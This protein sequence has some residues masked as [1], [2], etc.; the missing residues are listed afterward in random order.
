MALTL[1]QELEFARF[2]SR[3]GIALPKETQVSGK[4]KKV[5]VWIIPDI[6]IEIRVTRSPNKKDVSS[7]DFV[8]L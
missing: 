6:N 2:L 8:K 1:Q 5:A 4:T 3:N 7:V